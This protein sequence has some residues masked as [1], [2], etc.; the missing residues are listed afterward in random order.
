LQRALGVA[1]PRWCHVPLVVDEHGR[2]Y[3][4]RSDDIALARLRDAGVDARTLVAWVARRSGIPRAETAT[5]REIAPAF[6]MARLP[7]E[8]VVVMP[9]DLSEL[10]VGS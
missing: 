4:K 9:S 7:R 1:S 2:R 6:D 10:G 5:A 8:P 3:A